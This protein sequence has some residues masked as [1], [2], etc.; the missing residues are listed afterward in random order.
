MTTFSGMIA[1]LAAIAVG[2]E[3]E[4]ARPSDLV[5][6]IR[7]DEF[8]T[9]LIELDLDG[10]PSTLMLDTGSSE[11]LHLTSATIEQIKKARFTGDVQRSGNMAGEVQEN[12]RFII[13]A[14]SINGHVFEGVTGVEFAP[15]AVT[16]MGSEQPPEFPVIGLGLFEGRSI[17][18]DYQAETL[19]ISE[20][21]QEPASGGQDNWVEVPFRRTEEGLLLDAVIAGQ[22][23][24]MSLDSGASIS[25]VM[26]DRTDAA[27]FAV[28]CQSIYPNLPDEGCELVPVET[29]FGSSSLTFNAFLM[30]EELGPF[31]GAGL[32]G[33]DFLFQHAVFID[34]KNNRMFVRPFA[35]GASRQ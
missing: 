13:D 30:H 22:R 12:A 29:K 11:G 1:I 7:F 17:L 15:W 24:S 20:T 21:S 4:T 32:L 25:M 10:T 5:L 28:P 2:G 8:A 3:T 6:P 16:F 26:A 9:P 19:S 31:E 35:S 14:L 18:I 33:G 23:R 34:F 27:S